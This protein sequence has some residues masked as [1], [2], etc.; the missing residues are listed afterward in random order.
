M[1][2]SLPNPIEHLFALT[3]EKMEQG[4]TA[5]R[6]SPRLRMILPV[7]RTQE[8]GVQRLLNFLQ[9]GT[10]IRPHQ[11]PLPHATES[12]C[13][14]A[15]HLEIIIFS[16]DG[17]IKERHH[18]T[19]NAPLIDLEPGIWHGIVVHQ[20]DSII[21]EVK[22]GPYNPETDKE[23]APWA[24]PEDSPEAQAYLARLAQ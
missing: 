11:H 5:S 7:Q 14:I 12:L 20:P 13:L 8:A 17:D 10:Y 2:N 23:F 9:P 6:Q 18:L 1:P 16:Q 3:P 4:R 15:G 19:S 24:P 22:Q 21:F